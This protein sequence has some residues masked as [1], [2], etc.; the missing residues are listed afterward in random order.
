MPRVTI[1]NNTLATQL[2]GNH[3]ANVLIDQIKSELDST[4]NVL[5]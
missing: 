3:T 2:P 5:D 4:K 1:T